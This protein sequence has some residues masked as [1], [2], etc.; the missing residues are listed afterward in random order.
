[1]EDILV[2]IGEVGLPIGGA[3]VAGYF[4]FLVM[5]QILEGLVDSISTLTILVF[6]LV[7]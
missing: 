6:F 7:C 3:L 5:K 4:I 1:M 2:L